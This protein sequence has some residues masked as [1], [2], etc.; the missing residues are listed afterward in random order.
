MILNNGDLVDQYTPVPANMD[1][2]YLKLIASPGESYRFEPPYF[3]NL[4]DV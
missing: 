2:L 3:S 1:Q 4:D